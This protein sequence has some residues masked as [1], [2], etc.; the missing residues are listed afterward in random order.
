MFALAVLS[1]LLLTFGTG[2]GS[3]LFIDGRLVP[4]TELGHLELD[5]VDAERRAASSVKDAHKMSYRRWAKRVNDYM[6]HVE[7]LFTPDL[8]VVGGGVSKDF[9]KWG[10]LLDLSTPVKPAQLLNDAGI[11]GAAIAASERF[12]E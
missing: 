1:V 12:G 11:V 4:N 9:E 5:G 8:F 2:I 3:A 6:Q 7:K 10:P